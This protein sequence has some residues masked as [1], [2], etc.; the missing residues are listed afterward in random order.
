MLLSRKPYIQDETIGCNYGQ[1]IGVIKQQIFFLSAG[2]DGKKSRKK[3]V[4]I[5]E[6]EK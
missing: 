4:T 3:T 2:F 1:N 5:G 6:N